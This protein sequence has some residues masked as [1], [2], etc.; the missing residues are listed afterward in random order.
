VKET[1]QHIPENVAAL[2]LTLLAIPT[3]LHVFCAPEHE[4]LGFLDVICLHA[5]EL[6]KNVNGWMN[7]SII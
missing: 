5:C 1:T 7:F 3:Y 6:R 4:K 2:K